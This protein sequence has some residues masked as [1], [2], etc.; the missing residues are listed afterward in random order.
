[1]KQNI[2]WSTVIGSTFLF[3]SLFPTTVMAEESNR[4]QQVEQPLATKILVTVGGV[5]L[6]GLELWWFLGSNNK[7]E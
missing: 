4:F 5:G 3:T 1:M 7:K 2:F 6:I